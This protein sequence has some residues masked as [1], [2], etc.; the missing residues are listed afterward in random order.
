MD[1]D[2]ATRTIVVEAFESLGIGDAETAAAIARDYR[3][4]RYDAMRLY[5]DAIETLQRARDD[6]MRTALITNGNARAQR[7]SVERFGL[8]R[9]F[10]CIIIEGEF[11]AGKPDERVF[12]HALA[13]CDVEP[14]TTWMVGDNIEADVAPAV[15]LGMHA[16]W[17]DASGGGVPG[18]APARPHRIIRTIGEL[19]SG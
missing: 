18:D 11:G 12:R 5:P 13:A 14:L 10:D 4:R 7:H 6:G 2:A 17:V 19:L 16:V 3:A 15:A 1:L 9:Y 8:E